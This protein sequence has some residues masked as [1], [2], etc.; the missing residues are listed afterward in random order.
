M[1]FNAELIANH[2]FFLNKSIMNF[3]M[4]SHVALH[5]MMLFLENYKIKRILLLYENFT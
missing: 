5:I 1:H 4:S 2:P 3:I